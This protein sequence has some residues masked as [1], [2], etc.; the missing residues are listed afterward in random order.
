MSHLTGPVVLQISVS[1]VFR[2]QSPKLA[3]PTTFL[4]VAQI[5][6]FYEGQQGCM[7]PNRFPGSIGRGCQG[8]DRATF[9]LYWEES[10]VFDFGAIVCLITRDGWF[11]HVR[12]TFQSNN[13][14]SF[15]PRGI[16]PLRGSFLCGAGQTL[17][18]RPFIVISKTLPL[19]HFLRP[20]YVAYIAL[21]LFSAAAPVSTLRRKFCIGK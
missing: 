3:L 2:P 7:S 8:P 9:S 16:L 12:L 15:G 11:R 4:A 18:W 14:F 1:L 20:S 13:L 19:L 10:F 17:S 6:A 21:L 5:L